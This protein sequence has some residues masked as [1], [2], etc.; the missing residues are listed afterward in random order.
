MSPEA[1][2]VQRFLDAPAVDVDTTAAAH[3]S[4]QIRAAIVAA[5]DEVEALAASAAMLA[6][7]PAAE[8]AAVMRIADDLLLGAADAAA[9][10]ELEPAGDGATLAALPGAD[11]RIPY[12]DDGATIQVA[13]PSAWRRQND[14]VTMVAKCDPAAAPP[15][16][17]AAPGYAAARDARA[18]CGT[19]QA[20]R[21]TGGDTHGQGA[22]GQC[23]W[24][25]IPV[26][27]AYTCDEWAPA[28]GLF[29]GP[30]VE[31]AVGQFEL[32]KAKEREYVRADDGKFGTGSGEGG[33]K[34][35]KP[36][37]EP[38]AAPA[39]PP[40][41]DAD[42]AA[43]EAAATAAGL[44]PRDA[45]VLADPSKLAEL[46]VEEAE[47][48]S[49]AGLLVRNDD[50]SYAPSELGAS[51]GA[52]VKAGDAEAAAASVETA[53]AAHQDEQD[54]AG[55]DEPPASDTGAAPD[56]TSGASSAASAGSGGSGGGSGG[57][58]GFRPPSTEQLLA[59][60]DAIPR[61]ERAANE[62]QIADKLKLDPGTL[63]AL[64]ELADPSERI[65]PSGENAER[66]KSMGLIESFEDGS[67][68]PTA[69]GRLLIAS[70]YAG[71]TKSAQLALDQGAKEVPTTKLRKRGAAATA[72]AAAPLHWGFAFTK[73]D[74]EQRIV[75]GYASSEALDSQPGVWKGVQYEGDVVDAASINA[76]LP[77]YLQYANIREMHQPSAVGLALKAEVIPGEVAITIDGRTRTLKNPLYLVVK[78][79]DDAAWAKVKAG[80]YKGFS[81][82]GA[83]VDAAVARVAGRLVRMIKGLQL[84]EISLVD[85]P[86][87]PDARIVLWKLGGSTPPTGGAMPTTIPFDRE[88]LAAA[89]KEALAGMAQPLAP[90]TGELIHKAADPSKVISA[91]QA[92]RN[93]AELGGD[94]EAAQMYTQAITLVMQAS[95]DADGA[96]AESESEVD[97]ETP[98]GDAMTET[99]ELAQA[100]RVTSLRKAGRV[101]A[102]KRMDMMRPVV[103]SLLQLMADS[104]DEE[105][106]RALKAYGL[107]DDPAPVAEL[108]AADAGAA[109]GKA[110][111]VELA[112][113]LRPLAET[114]AKMQ[115]D[116]GAI[117]DAV[118]ALSR[119]ARPGGPA[120]RAVPVTK[121]LTTDPPRREAEPTEDVGELQRLANTEPDPKLRAY[122]Q[123]RLYKWHAH[124]R[125][126]NRCPE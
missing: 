15:A 12:T 50:G 93:D 38:K 74:G 42:A 104:G 125:R 99:T 119:I 37:A 120:Q 110:L 59:T 46:P 40:A 52:Q 124:Q 65:A 81:I 117:A 13:D 21:V 3:V 105:A 9:D 33:G 107:A 92:L 16:P 72:G 73:V 123:Q 118:D 41:A 31:N 94:V 79:V 28:V 88:T 35:D 126:T 77:D 61:D 108:G 45:A 95:G 4:D 17:T 60:R 90:L 6:E 7:L 91:I 68:A 29:S 43:Q 11:W 85:R 22:Y 80:V 57:G 53:A 115:Q 89:F 5:L 23:L 83:V 32:D 27:A 100:A 55:K 82:G 75:E 44:D 106:A 114:I 84:T 64:S 98:A 20:F 102:R 2:R 39:E 78:V 71:D 24:F 10:V 1:A 101:M 14:E 67:A 87:N 56:A 58:E 48:L 122:Y 121:S 36:K 70:A 18:S 26:D 112:S 69:A 51:V 66:L 25:D 86:A 96:A 97:V 76:A 111:G 8:R 109:I 63:G 19:C 103:K 30:A 62:Q 49:A 113:G 47:R 54:A 116:Q 34:P